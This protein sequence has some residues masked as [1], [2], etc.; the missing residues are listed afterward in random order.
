MDETNRKRQF[1]TYGLGGLFCV[2]IVAGLLVALFSHKQTNKTV[3]DRQQQALAASPYADPILQ[4]LPYGDLGYNI[5]PS[6]KTFNGKSSL[7]IEIA[8]TFSG[9][10]YKLTPDEQSALIKQRQQAALNYIRSKGL[11]PGEY[12][13][14]YATPLP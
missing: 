9:V 4:Y 11:D 2:L 3:L 12:R 6:L 14:E 1:I 7:V 13:V 10:D 8:V 5:S